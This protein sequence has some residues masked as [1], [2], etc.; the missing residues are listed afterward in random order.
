M[1]TEERLMG[2][3]KTT[4]PGYDFQLYRNKENERGDYLIWP[5]TL[6]YLND[7]PIF[8]YSVERRMAHGG[9]VFC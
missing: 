8:K 6:I 5:L 7:T 1:E 2:I 4:V 9:F 3:L